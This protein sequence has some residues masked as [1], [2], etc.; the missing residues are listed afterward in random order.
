MEAQVQARWYHT[1]RAAG[2]SGA[3]CDRIASAFAYPGFR[4]KAQAAL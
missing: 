2:V 1:A 4:L 3:D